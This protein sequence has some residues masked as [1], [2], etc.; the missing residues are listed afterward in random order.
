MTQRQLSRLK[1][2][3]G[4]DKAL[5]RRKSDLWDVVASADPL[6][7]R[8][9]YR[10]AGT[11]HDS[12]IPENDKL[13]KHSPGR[14]DFVD[15]IDERFRPLGPSGR[16]EWLS[17]NHIHDLLTMLKKSQFR[18]I[19]LTY[20]A[21]VALKL[22]WPDTYLY[23]IGADRGRRSAGQW[24][25]KQAEQR[26]NPWKR[27]VVVLNLGTLDSGGSHW[28]LIYVDRT[29][30]TPGLEYYD[31]MNPGGPAARSDAGRLWDQFRRWN[32]RGLFRPSPLPERVNQTA[33][34]R[35]G[36]ECGMFVLW[37]VMVR[38]QGR[39]QAW[40][41]QPGRINDQRCI[42]LRREYFLHHPSSSSRSR[43]RR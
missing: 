16:N 31:A 43:R 32:Q 7:G 24:A 39:S 10:W 33:H 8:P 25:R 19:Y 5:S 42:Q 18:G 30:Q 2:Y 36:T 4:G 38:I 23:P 11:I 20:P 12:L 6:A 13:V 34:Q 9:E 15:S 3:T 1:R 21:S 37:Y 40:A 22:L 29:K 26:R 17:S 28:V 41:D 14:S 35:G 27:Y